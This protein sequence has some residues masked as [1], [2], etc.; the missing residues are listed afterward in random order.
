MQVLISTSSFNLDNFS[1]LSDLKNA[2]VEVKLNPFAARL[3]EDQVIELLGTD[4][5]GLI[6]GLEPLTKNVLQVAKS[7]KVIARV[8]T[9]L[10]SVDLATAKQLGITVL[11]TPDA[12]TKAVAELTLAHI[13]GLLRHVSQADRQVRVGVWKGLMGSLLET[14]TVGIVGF[15]RIGKRVAT[16][17]SAFGAS[18]IISDAQV[19]KSVY[20]NVELDELCIKSDILSLHLPYNEATHHIINEKNLNLMKKGSYIV[21]ISRGGLV[22]ETALLAALKSGHLAGAALDCFEQEP[23]EGELRNLETVQITAHMGSYARETRDLMEQEASRLLVD[24][25]HEKNLLK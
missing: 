9:G 2:G 14:K 6:A 20:P 25:L 7:L 10:D 21:N 4:T 22:D 15:G 24:A 5:I 17:L 16:L 13:L 3:T 12:P 8:G 19:S 1:Q 23:Y 18:V 11:N